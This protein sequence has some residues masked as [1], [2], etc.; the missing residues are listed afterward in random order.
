M[1]EQSTKTES[2]NSVIEEKTVEICLQ[3]GLLPGI[4][5]YWDQKHQQTGIRYSLRLAKANVEALLTSRGLIDAVRKPRNQGWAII[6]IIL[7]SIAI[8]I[9]LYSRSH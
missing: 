9:Y 2:I 5:Y 6:A 1:L 8:A 3:K 7:F 4:K